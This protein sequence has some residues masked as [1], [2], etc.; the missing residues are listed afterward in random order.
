MDMN[1]EF[2]IDKRT[3]KPYRWQTKIIASERS[4][5]AEAAEWLTE[6]MEDKDYCKPMIKKVGKVYLATLVYGIKKILKY[7]IE[8]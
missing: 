6:Q 8:S 1:V 3:N 2:Q 4:N 7:K 5:P